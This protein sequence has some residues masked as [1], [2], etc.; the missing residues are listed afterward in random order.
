MKS[1][2]D[3][4]LNVLPTIKGLRPLKILSIAWLSYLK[5][6]S[7]THLFMA[8]VSIFLVKFIDKVMLKI[9][10]VLQTQT[11]G[12]HGRMFLELPRLLNVAFALRK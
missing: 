4:N 10:G 11:K 12:V 1:S 9:R 7:T 5:K 2:R 3:I 8:N 6:K